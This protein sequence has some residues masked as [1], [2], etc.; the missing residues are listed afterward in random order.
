MPP[1]GNMNERVLTYPE[2]HYAD[3]VSTIIE[4]TFSKFTCLEAS[5]KEHIPVF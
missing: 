2:V 3:Y 5:E 4:I 1:N